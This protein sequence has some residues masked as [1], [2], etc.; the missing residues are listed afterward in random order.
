MTYDDTLLARL[1]AGVQAALPRWGVGSDADLALLT[2][3]ENATYLIR[4]GERRLILRVH[5]PNYHS[6]TEIAGELA[7]IADLRVQ[8]VVPTPRPVPT[9]DGALVVSFR[10]EAD[11]RYV[12]AFEHMA[13]SEPNAGDDLPR[14]YRHLGAITARL[15]S[16]A[17]AWKRPQ[18]FQRKTWTFDTMIGPS[19]YWGDWR[20]AEGIDPAGL[21]VLEQVHERLKAQTTAYGQAADRFGLI[22]CDMRPANLLV[23]GDRLGVIDF[24]D[25]GLSWFAYDFAASIS[26]MEHEP[27]IP[28]LMDAWC[29]G[30]RSIAPFP[31]EQARALPMF[32]MLRRMQLLAWVASHAETPTAQAMGPAFTRGTIELAKTY[33]ATSGAGVSA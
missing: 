6:E 30:Y 17:R 14:W 1:T 18:G 12:V 27:I 3:S 33:L 31:D 8:A 29:D 22:H 10:D 26:F 19:G 11:T 4:D 7:W 23:D 25:C 13:G 15:H 16:H 32:V 5:R 9:V 2:V 21:A 20:D 24:D 28:A